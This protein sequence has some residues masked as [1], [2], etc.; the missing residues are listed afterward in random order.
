MR[1]R[2]ICLWALLNMLVEDR[3]MSD[4]SRLW[5]QVRCEAGGSGG[6]GGAAGAHTCANSSA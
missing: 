1:V 2:F 4:W 3:R 6:G 5:G